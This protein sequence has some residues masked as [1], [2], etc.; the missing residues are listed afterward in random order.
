MPKDVVRRIRER[1]DQIA[2]DPYSQWRSVTRLQ[3][4]PGFRL[5][6]GDWR[7]ISTVQDDELIVLVLKIGTRGEIY[8]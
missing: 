3:N 8:R 7:V 5:R 4:R 2:T 6:I 1:L